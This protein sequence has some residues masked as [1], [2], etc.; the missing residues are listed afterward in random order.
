MFVQYKSYHSLHVFSCWVKGYIIQLLVN[1][2]KVEFW[3]QDFQDF[4]ARLHA[5]GCHSDHAARSLL[6][7]AGSQVVQGQRRQGVT[8]LSAAQSLCVDCHAVSSFGLVSQVPGPV[9]EGLAPDCKGTTHFLSE[10]VCCRGQ[11]PEFRKD[12]WQEVKLKSSPRL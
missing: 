12:L 3:T 5:W 11:Q 4:E 6:G 9:F 8:V 1:S 10:V 2:S 7:L